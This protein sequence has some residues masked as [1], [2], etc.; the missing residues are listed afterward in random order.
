M[1]RTLVNVMLAIV[2]LIGGAVILGR[3][4]A[5]RQSQPPPQSQL[6]NLSET[7]VLLADVPAAQIVVPVASQGNADVSFNI[8]GAQSVLID[9]MPAM[10]MFQVV[11]K[12]PIGE[13]SLK[14]SWGAP[15]LQVLDNDSETPGIQIA[16]AALPDG[17]EV[18]HSEVDASGMWQY[19]VRNLTTSGVYTQNLALVLLE[20]REPGMAGIVIE[21]ATAQAPDGT[22]LTVDYGQPFQVMVHT[23]ESLP[24]AVAPP[25]ADLNLSAPTPA[26]GM[27][28]SAPLPTMPV[29]LTADALAPG[30]YYRI[31]RGQNLFR[32]AQAFG[33][34]V[35]A[36]M[37]ANHITD[38]RRVPT[39]MLLYIP[40]PS[41]KGQ[42]A[43]LVG[44]GE[45]LYGIAR[46][47]GM[48]VEE[49]AALNGIAPPYHVSAGLYLLVRP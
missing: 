37:Q 24:P 21:A 22:A 35:E 5:A 33:V 25:A 28:P 42:S 13:L 17:A 27:E 23:G 38:A 34:T 45:T 1:F 48:T 32:L 46:T 40:A 3:C 36:L 47:F 16:L 29:A 10:F 49:L 9:S 31:Q 7:D 4:H 20:G 6:A 30:I 41:P 43:Y 8:S 2:L 39:G 19:K 14:V 18:L 12:R 11:G 26:I 15:Y 44:P